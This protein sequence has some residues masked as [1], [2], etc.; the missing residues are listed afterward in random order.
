MSKFLSLEG[1]LVATSNSC[2]YRFELHSKIA[3]SMHNAEVFLIFLGL[4]FTINISTQVRNVIVRGQTVYYNK[5]MNSAPWM[6]KV[7]GNELEG[8]AL[9][10]CSSAG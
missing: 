8:T 6:Q 7:Y 4:L 5:Q 2:L 3:D 10:D 9:M 1:L